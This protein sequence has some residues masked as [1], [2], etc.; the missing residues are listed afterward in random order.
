MT[1]LTIQTKLLEEKSLLGDQNQ[2]WM[3]M[4]D[5]VNRQKSWFCEK[6]TTGWVID[7]DSCFKTAVLTALWV[8]AKFVV[9][10]LGTVTGIMPLISY[11]ERVMRP[12]PPLDF[13]LQKKGF[14][15]GIPLGKGAQGRVYLVTDI[16]SNQFA[17]K[18]FLYY[19]RRLVS[20][21]TKR[22][23]ALAPSLPNHP[24]FLKTHKFIIT[25]K[26]KHQ[27][28]F[29]NPSDLHNYS[30]DAYI[31]GILTPFI[32]N[33]K[34][35]NKVIAKKHLTK[36]QVRLIGYQV[37]S[38]LKALHEKGLMHRDIK[39]E[40]ILV[41]EDWNVKIIDFGFLKSLDNGR[42]KT[43]CG[44]L[45]YMAPDI[46]RKHYFQDYGVK[47]EAWSFGILL[48]VMAFHKW[49]SCSNTSNPRMQY[50]LDWIERGH[51]IE[52][53]SDKPKFPIYDQDFWNL[54]NKLICRESKRITVAEALNE[55]F[56]KSCIL[57]RE[58]VR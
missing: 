9:Q 4:T 54:L 46:T 2:E 22:G 57:H 55:P 3:D 58:T 36:E 10:L 19:D 1:Q 27:R 21:G 44:P 16:D 37:A 47:A 49:P 39:L 48:Y 31:S 26:S 28:K 52:S 41:D 24:A 18:E 33:T 35:L 43:P 11:I 17:C 34:D 25:S 8:T 5:A 14:K 32:P 40:N 53:C 12:S 45:E 56:F 13:V 30:K 38:G 7:C 20:I 6:W 42:A 50:I 29:V 51:T 15:S 23:E